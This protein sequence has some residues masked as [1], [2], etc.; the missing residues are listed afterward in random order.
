MEVVLW[1]LF[2]A[3]NMFAFFLMMADKR[4][5]MNRK[6]RV[7]ERR[8]WLAAWCGGAAGA[9]FGMKRFRHKTKHAAFRMG[10]PLLALVQ[11]A[12]AVWLLIR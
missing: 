11:A 7:P 2:A 3:M 8:L 6:W 4:R 9:Y 12:A 5:A 1:G 10:L